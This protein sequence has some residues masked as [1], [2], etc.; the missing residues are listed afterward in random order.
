MAADFPF[1][2]GITGGS[3]SGKTTLAQ[4]LAVNLQEYN[5]VILSQDRYFRDLSACTLEEREKIRTG[6]RPEAILWTAYLDAVHKIRA[7]EPIQ[8]P[9]PGTRAARYE[10]EPF[11]IQPGQVL[12]LEGLFV[13]WS[14][15]LRKLLNLAIYVEVEDSERILRRLV[16]D[17]HSQEGNL[18]RAVSWMRRDVLPNFPVFT[19]ASKQYADLIVPNLQPDNRAVLIIAQGVRSILE[20]KD[21]KPFKLVEWDKNSPVPHSSWWQ[22]KGW[23][24]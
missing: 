7:G 16:R 12:I 6:N 8:E 17:L 13:L 3:A 1:T 14:E 22:S 11:T 23:R 15:E 4:A 19:G 18:D 9:A 21:F 20:G 5:P 2:I 24:R 10:A